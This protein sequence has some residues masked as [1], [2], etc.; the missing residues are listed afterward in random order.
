VTD[1][2]DDLAP[3]LELDGTPI[4]EL[5][6]R[7]RHRRA[8][9][10]LLA[11]AACAVVAVLVGAGSFAAL[12]GDHASTTIVADDP[13]TPATEAPVTTDPP[14]DPTTTT[15]AP[16]EAPAQIVVR[17]STA[18][19][20]EIVDLFVPGEEIRGVLF[21]LARWDGAAWEPPSFGLTSDGQGSYDCRDCPSWT[22]GPGPYGADDIGSGGPGP[23]RVEIPEVA[24]PGRYRVCTG[25]AQVELC[26]QVE[27]AGSAD[28]APDPP[29]A[30]HEPPLVTISRWLLRPGERFDLGFPT[31]L[32]RGVVSTLERWT[33]QEWTGPLVELHASTGAGGDPSVESTGAT[34]P[35]VQWSGPGPDPLV[36]PEELTPG[37]YRICSGGIDVTVCVQVRVLDPLPDEPPPSTSTSTAPPTS[38]EPSTTTAPG[39]PPPEASPVALVVSPDVVWAGAEAD[40]WFP[41]QAMRGIPFVLQRWDGA[42]WAEPSFS[43]HSDWGGGR[44]TP[45]W[46]EGGSPAARAI[47]IGGLGPDRVVIPDIA[48]PGRY[49][50]CVAGGVDDVCGQLEIAAAPE[51]SPPPSTEAEHEVELWH[52]G[53]L[54]TEFA[55]ATWVADP[56]P[57]DG[58]NAPPGAT[59]GTMTELQPDA[60]EARYVGSDGTVVRFIR[61]VGEWEPPPC[62]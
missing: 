39:S 17:P 9:R 56:V 54:P 27:I 42:A 33:G 50:L 23:D 34:A 30:E 48:E 15:A 31:G 37:W 58:T 41:T 52:C 5:A 49:R 25:N 36:L 24:P 12:G 8:R 40:L 55:G 11:G 46:E 60:D 6:A 44:A 57:F 20:G 29:P 1:L 26:G 51:S 21:T 38:I 16:P 53:I 28:A 32:P 14:P 3:L 7:R 19:P 45:Y 10:R 4:A 35:A 13:T 2:R 18:R 59:V 47:G 61:L 62:L 43:L 22:A